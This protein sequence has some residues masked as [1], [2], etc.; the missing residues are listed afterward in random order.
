MLFKEMC[1]SVI[2]QKICWVAPKPHICIKQYIKGIMGLVSFFAF[3]LPHS[4]SVVV[5]FPFCHA[6]IM[7]CITM[8]TNAS[9]YIFMSE[10]QR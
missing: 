3:L 4:R 8:Q 5:F 7:A 1:L 6:L 10:C 9:S 2:K